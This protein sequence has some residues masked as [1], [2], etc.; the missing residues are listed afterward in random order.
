VSPTAP[1]APTVAPTP[2]KPEPESEI[3][4]KKNPTIKFNG[5]EYD[6][7]SL[8]IIFMVI[9][10]WSLI[11]K[12]TGLWK[13][14]QYD[15]SFMVIFFAFIL[16]MLM[17]ARSSGIT[18][19]GVVYELNILLSVEQMISILFGT[20][21]LFA[22][23]H[24]KIDV[25]AN[26]KPVIFK[27]VMSTVMILTAA[28]LWINVYTTGRAFRAVRK[29]KQGIYNV[30]LTLLLIIGLIYVKGNMCAAATVTI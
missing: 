2:T 3:G 23:F 11:W 30:S 15:K 17:T 18:S 1:T 16:Y 14:L 29:F 27:L 7:D 20:V 5:Y 12:T 26:C 4:E 6:K 19:G 24:N 28:S 8:V 25:H 21:I 9:F 22:I 10:I 13:V